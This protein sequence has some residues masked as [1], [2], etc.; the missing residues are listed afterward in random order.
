MRKLDRF[1]AAT[2]LFTALAAAADNSYAISDCVY[3]G[4]NFSDG[5]ISCQ[6]GNQ[7]QC[8]DGDWQPLDTPCANAPTPPIEVSPATCSCSDAEMAQCDQKGENCC[9]SLVSGNCLRD[10][11]PR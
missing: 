6:S 3:G 8:S 5:A 11:C 9:V 10:C 1:L 2:C 4:V 7:F